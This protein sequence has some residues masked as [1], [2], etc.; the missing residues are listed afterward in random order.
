MTE[1]KKIFISYRHSD[2]AWVRDTLYP[3]L[4]AGG[5]Q[6]VVDYKDFDAGIAL[7][8]Q[9]S[10]KQ[11]TA[12]VH[13]LVLTADY[14]TSDYCL[15]EMRRAVATD[16]QFEKGTV[17]PIVLQQCALPPEIK[18]GGPLYV[19]LSG[20][21]NLDAEGWGR[22]MKAC[23]ADLGMSPP[24][25]LRAYL[26]TRKALEER[27]SVNLLVKGLPKWRELIDLL[28]LTLP[29]LGVV[30]LESGKTSKR[31]GLVAEI[32]REVAGYNGKIVAGQDLTD[33]ERVLE[34]KPPS[35]LALRHFDKA[36]ERDYGSDLYSSL[37]YLIM[38]KRAL[39]L[40]VQSRAP[41]ATLLPKNHALSYLEMETV[42][43]NGNT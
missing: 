36:A 22:V 4:S 29:A 16:P 34:S 42:E 37:R 7:R 10:E 40:L 33:L 12:D 13:L 5:A 8:K 31:R 32:L 1:E 11:A 18:G 38:E 3:V 6:V 24:H 17:L 39:T 28:K 14:F 30:D 9:I 23:G 25:W 41:F 20:A 2:A 43:L 35:L 27:R 15:E 21:R 26:A 19:D